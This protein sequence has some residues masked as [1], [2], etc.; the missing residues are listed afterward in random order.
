MPNDCTFAIANLIPM[1]SAGLADAALPLILE[2]STLQHKPTWYSVVMLRWLQL[3]RPQSTRGTSVRSICMFLWSVRLLRRFDI[4]TKCDRRSGSSRP[5]EQQV[6]ANS[7]APQAGY[8]ILY[9]PQCDSLPT[10]QNLCHST[11]NLSIRRTFK[12]LTQW[13]IC[14]R[15]IHTLRLNRRVW[16]ALET[17]LIILLHRFH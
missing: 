11:D 13:T 6:P 8:S 1:E 4:M 14:Y 10:L 17:F 9:M 3:K 2:H 15:S 7:S 12:P 5:I 16:A